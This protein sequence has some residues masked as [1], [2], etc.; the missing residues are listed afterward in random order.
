M[1]RINKDKNSETNNS[2]LFMHNL[3]PRTFCCHGERFPKL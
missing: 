3:G 1:T 2:Q